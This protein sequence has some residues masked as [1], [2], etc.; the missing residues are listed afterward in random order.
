[1]EF[2]SDYKLPD[3]SS[4]S[5]VSCGDELSKVKEF[6]MN[7]MPYEINDFILNAKEVKADDLDFNEEEKEGSDSDDSNEE[8]KAMLNE[9]RKI[10][11]FKP[12]FEFVDE[13]WNMITLTVTERIIIKG[14]ELTT[15]QF[16]SLITAADG[17]SYIAIIGN[18]IENAGMIKLPYS[19]LRNL[20]QLCNSIFFT[21]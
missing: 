17:W 10:E 20:K 8:R 5:I 18:K 19:E 12:S 16:C 11:Y 2:L 13:L 14:L 15:Q 9:K 7:W 21:N 4:L 1:M 3:L 6:I